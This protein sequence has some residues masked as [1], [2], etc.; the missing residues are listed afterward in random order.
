MLIHVR[1]CP[2]RTQCPTNVSS[3]PLVTWIV[4]KVHSLQ[5]KEKKKERFRSSFMWLFWNSLCVYNHIKSTA[6][7]AYYLTHIRILFIFFISLCLFAE[8]YLEWFST[9][10]DIM[11][12][13][14]THRSVD[15]NQQS[16]GLGQPCCC[17]V[18][19]FLLNLR[20]R[21]HIWKDQ[22]WEKLIF[23]FSRGR[24]HYFISLYSAWQGRKKGHS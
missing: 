1:S 15:K 8:S 21:S 24:I 22:N 6:E 17:A 13:T 7:Q 5:R 19:Y 9:I 23:K 10:S 3:A 16:G 20:P 12:S 14:L 11:W 18:S 4:S 2:V